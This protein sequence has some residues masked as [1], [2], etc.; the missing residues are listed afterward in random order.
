MGEQRNSLVV[1]ALPRVVPW[2]V[3][4]RRKDALRARA[5]DTSRPGLGSLASPAPPTQFVVLEI[6]LTR[7]GASSSVGDPSTGVPSSPVSDTS[8][9]VT[10]AAFGSSS[11]PVATKQHNFGSSEAT[12]VAN[13]VN[14]LQPDFVVITATFLSVSSV[15]VLLDFPRPHLRT[16]SLAFVL[17]DGLG[18]RRNSP[19]L[20][21]SVSCGQC[22][23]KNSR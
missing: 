7:V 2:P 22:C 12:V 8:S 10:V 15:R 16:V 20:R 11:A 23:G 21:L 1:Q 13:A 6:N 18:P 4:L 17:H 14:L 9:S 3:S 19:L 5:G